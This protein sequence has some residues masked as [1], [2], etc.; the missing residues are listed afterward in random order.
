M[1]AHASI[2]LAHTHSIPF[3][4]HVLPQN[5]VS[6]LDH[7]RDNYISSLA[8]M[9]QVRWLDGRQAERARRRALRDSR[10]T[11]RSIKGC[12]YPG[13]WASGSTSTSAL[14]VL[15]GAGNG[16]GVG[17]APHNTHRNSLWSLW[18]GEKG[19]SKER[20]LNKV[21]LDE[22][23]QELNLALVGIAV[24]WEKDHSLLST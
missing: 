10:K 24:F 14:F 12:V 16:S 5:L 11:Q 6:G 3:T 4:V 17:S 9:L 1:N 18:T 13:N 7:T 19:G 23:G 21:R 15:L 8:K 20:G 2:G 22:L